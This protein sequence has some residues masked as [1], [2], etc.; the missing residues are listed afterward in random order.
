MTRLPCS[1]LT[2]ELRG[3]RKIPKAT[4]AL[5]QRHFRHEGPH[6]SRSREWNDGDKYSTRRKAVKG[7]LSLRLEPVGVG[8]I[9][10]S[11][12]D[13]CRIAAKLG[14]HHV[15][16]SSNGY[17]FGCYAG[18]TAARFSESMDPL[19]GHWT[20]DGHSKT[21]DGLTWTHHPPIP[22]RGAVKP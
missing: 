6:Q 5:C 19:P 11:V 9:D 21:E 17:M 16:F 10:E 8:S 1:K 4:F 3:G 14:L 12:E 7:V 15:V 22:P 13:G 2:P 20:W 18:G